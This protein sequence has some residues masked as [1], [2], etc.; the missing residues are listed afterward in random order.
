MY[1]KNKTQVKVQQLNIY[2]FSLTIFYEA[3][4]ALEYLTLVSSI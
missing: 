4:S 3:I 2:K 1:L